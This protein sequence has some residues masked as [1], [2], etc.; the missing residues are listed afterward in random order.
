MYHF[1]HSKK[2]VLLFDLDD[3]LCNSSRIKRDVLKKIYDNFPQ[4]NFYP[5]EDFVKA[6]KEGNKYYKEINKTY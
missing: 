2:P 5:F 3:T 6:Y 1:S 4:I